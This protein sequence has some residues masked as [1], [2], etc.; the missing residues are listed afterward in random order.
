MNY[1]NS[2]NDCICISY[3]KSESTPRL[4]IL[5]LRTKDIQLLP[6][7]F[8]SPIFQSKQAMNKL[9]HIP[10]KSQ[11]I[12]A[13]DGLICF[14]VRFCHNSL[15]VLKMRFQVVSFASKKIQRFSSDRRMLMSLLSVLFH[16]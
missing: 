6:K 9:H 16:L 11:F 10:L 12:V 15:L 7:F 3:P 2:S 8:K 1:L 14:S 4:Q 5:T 13:L